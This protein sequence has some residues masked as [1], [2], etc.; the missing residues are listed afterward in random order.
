MDRLNRMARLSAQERQQMID[1]FAAR[2]CTGPDTGPELR[3]RLRGDVHRLP[4]DPT[5]EQLE[6]WLELSE[7]VSDPDFQQLAR[8]AVEQS[9]TG[10]TAPGPGSQP[11]RHRRGRP[12]HQIGLHPV[13]PPGVAFAWSQHDRLDIFRHASS[14]IEGHFLSRATAA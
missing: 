6:A 9:A 8:R 13:Y 10:S 14:P 11:D 7:L 12:A 5:Q 4:D 1:D 2:A 3:D